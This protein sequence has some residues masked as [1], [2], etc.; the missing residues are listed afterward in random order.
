MEISARDYKSTIINA[1]SSLYP[2]FKGTST[3]ENW[4]LKNSSKGYS[5]AVDSIE[6]RVAILD[7]QYSNFGEKLSITAWSKP[8]KM[9]VEFD[10]NKQ[11]SVNLPEG[12]TKE[13]DNTIVN[14]K[15]KF[16]NELNIFD[17]GIVERAREDI[18]VET[19][20]EHIKLTLAN[21]QVL[22]EGNPKVE[23]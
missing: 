1:K 19:T 18:F 2:I 16:P 8:F 17:F 4:H 21:G 15:T 7:L 20:T 22:A 11:S 3:D 13:G 5:I 9:Q 6:E 10:A 12:I 23:T 14:G